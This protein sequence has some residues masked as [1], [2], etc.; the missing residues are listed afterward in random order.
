[1][2]LLLLWL[3]LGKWL[4]KLN[5][6]PI[7]RMISLRNRGVEPSIMGIGPAQAVPKALKNSR[8]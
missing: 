4:K 3:C 8:S 1:M 7:A 2:A 6:E 5:L